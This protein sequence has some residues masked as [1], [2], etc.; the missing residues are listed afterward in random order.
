MPVKIRI[1]T[2][3]NESTVTH[4]YFAASPDGEEIELP[5]TALSLKI[6][7]NRPAE[8][9]A[10][11]LAYDVNQHTMIAEIVR[12]DVICLLCPYCNEKLVREEHRDLDGNKFIGWACGCS[13]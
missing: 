4:V 1:E 9:T 7:A 6:V 3:T 13:Q 12:A 8:I 2:D 11:F 10:S 5:L